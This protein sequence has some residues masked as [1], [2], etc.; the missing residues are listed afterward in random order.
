MRTLAGE[1]RIIEVPPILGFGAK[2]LPKAGVPPNAYLQYE[3][4]L[5]AINANSTP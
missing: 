3:V 1:R 2:G 4:E 5:L